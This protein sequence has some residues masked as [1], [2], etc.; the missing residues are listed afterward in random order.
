MEKNKSEAEGRKTLVRK[1]FLKNVHEFYREHL[2]YT[3]YFVEKATILMKGM[4][5]KNDHMN[6]LN[7]I[8]DNRG[9]LN[10]EVL[11]LAV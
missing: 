1:K 3:H 11:G 10:S 9:Y 5:E 2:R 8:K 6:V 7:L 4:C